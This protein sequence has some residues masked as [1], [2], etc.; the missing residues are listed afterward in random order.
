MKKRIKFKYNK[1]SPWL[2]YV[3]L[4]AAVTLG[5]LAYYLFLIVSGINQGPYGGPEYFRNHTNL[6]L[7]LIFGLI[8]VAMLV[9]TFISLRIW[10]AKD[11]EG[12]FDIYDDHVVLYWKGEKLRIKRGELKIEL[13]RPQAFCYTTYILK[14]SGRRIVLVASPNERKR[15]S[16]KSSLEKAL[17]ELA[18]SF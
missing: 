5:L 12:R 15:G 14:V 10:G 2:L 18:N 17:Q 6:A 3:M 9:P 16:G 11:E 4:I 8:P 7:L 1:Y 13:P